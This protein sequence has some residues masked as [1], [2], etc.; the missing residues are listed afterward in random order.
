MVT[1]SL[2]HSNNFAK[3][4]QS[5]EMRNLLL[6]ADFK[7]IFDLSPL[8]KMEPLKITKIC[9]IVCVNWSLGPCVSS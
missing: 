8:P 2:V 7:Q 6:Q 9:K 1:C 3:K 5:S 4:G